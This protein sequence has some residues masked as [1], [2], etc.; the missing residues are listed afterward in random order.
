MRVSEELYANGGVVEKILNKFGYFK[1]NKNKR[2]YK[3]LRYK[4]PDTP[5]VNS[6]RLIEL[7]VEGN[8]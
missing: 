7:M 8:E 3:D 4:E 5:E 6:E 2:Q 1:R